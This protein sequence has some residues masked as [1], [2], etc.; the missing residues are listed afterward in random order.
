MRLGRSKNVPVYR[1]EYVY[2]ILSAPL[3][4]R[5]HGVP[6]AALIRDYIHQQSQ[7]V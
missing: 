6:L 4:R 2:D 1:N 3:V 5:A 7:S